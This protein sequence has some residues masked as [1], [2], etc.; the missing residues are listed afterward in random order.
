MVKYSLEHKGVIA[1]FYFLI[2][3]MGLSSWETIGK[4]ENPEFP[5]FNAVVITKWPGASPQKIEELV[6]E[7]IEKKLLELPYWDNVKSLTQPGVSYVFPKIK[8]SIWTV[9]PI[10]DK[11]RNKLED[12]NGQLPDGV[13]TP[14]LNTDFGTTKTIVLAITGK[15]FTNKELDD[16][17]DD[18]RKDLE[19]V[20]YVAK[21]EIK[22]KQQERIW[23]EFPLTK[24]AAMGLDAQTI[25]DIV[26]DQNILE[27]GGRLWLGPQTIRVETSGEYK[28]VEEIE[29]TIINIP[30]QSNTIIL[31][32]LVTINREYE[33]PPKMQMRYMGKNA[34]G[35]VLQ[36]QAGGQILELG[37]NVKK[38]ISDYENIIP[39]GIDIDILNFQPMWTAIKIEDFV[40][41]LVQAIIT[42]GLFMVVLLGWREGL[43]IAT[44]IPSAFLIT[45]V[46]MDMISL[47]L[48]QISLAGYIIALGMLV[49]NGIV[50]VES[51]SGYI[52][53]GMDKAEAAIKAGKELM[54]PLL[55]ATATT[56]AA[57]LP[58]ALARESV[59][60][61]CQSLPIVVMIVLSASF[62][63]SMTL[64]PVSCVKLIQPKEEA[65]NLFERIFA[66][67]YPPVLG[68]AL[69]FKYITV[70][71]MVG[72]LFL[73][74]PLAGK[75]PKMFFPASDR[76]QFYFDLYMPEG[77]DFRETRKVALE[78]EKYV[79]SKYNEEIRNM[80]TYIGEK[81]PLYHVS[82]SGE[83]QTSNYAQFV[84][85]TWEQSQ[86]LKML[87]ELGTY[88]QNTLTEGR[89]DMRRVEEGPPVGAPIQVRVFGKD[90]NELYEYADQV[91]EVMKN[92]P[93]TTTLFDD[94]GKKVPLVYI[95]L[96]QDQARR[97]GV[98]TQT[99][100]R[101]M[102]AIFSGTRITDYREQ[103]DAIPIV[104]RASSRERNNLNRIQS[105][106]IPTSQGGKLPLSQVADVKIKWE[107]GKIR[108]YDRRRT[109][110]LKAYLDGTR[111][112]DLILKDVEN[113]IKQNIKFPQGYGVQFGG[114]KEAAGKAQAALKKSLPLGGAML[115]L[116]LV[117]QFGNVRK[118]LII[119][120]TIP[121]SFIGVVLGLYVVNYP[122]S[123]FGI[124]G[125]LSLAGIVVNNAILLIE[126]TDVNLAEGKP[127]IEALIDAGVRRAYP[128]I[129]TTITTLAG[130]FTLA[131]S[132][133]FW[134]PMA[135][136]IMGGLIVSTFLTLVVAPVLYAIFFNI[137]TSPRQEFDLEKDEFLRV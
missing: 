88:F 69:R 32:D 103:D 6:T 61:Y 135:V 60:I 29:N 7:K 107:A 116:I 55:A 53:Q 117:L 68:F 24:L 95:D 126:Q 93:G 72:V 82:I 5:E 63:V 67:I 124:L 134:G 132:G 28:S 127:P 109:I 57:F 33:D 52:K 106:E 96:N 30:G 100:T 56:V 25:T 11:T 15:G 40:S 26:R 4:Q 14:W 108:H 89:V 104:G 66:K 73:S 37:E 3:V 10:W 118:M 50:M 115:M 41:N 123:F 71:S 58:I 54:I 90:F 51:T 128:I 111:T 13:T 17:A 62:F 129:L 75:L 97:T 27:P 31:K 79:L 137:N 64:V 114:E 119:L 87:D 18:L 121:L 84:V 16:I 8:G 91:R 12:L 76:P 44:L 39:L 2:L 45:F 94:W 74:L 92:I 81:S 21:V 83:E 78:A 35:V 9:K 99:I 110:T 42:V 122:L 22:G 19:Q 112:A 70:V 125:I 38:L 102:Q 23:L 113:Q 47:P 105:F 20:Q 46:V 36:M 86:S 1:F 130:L 131:I 101:N 80:A 59:G 77:T 65:P 43:I 85:N 48:Q 34:I 98:T 49:D 136:A 133:L 120:T